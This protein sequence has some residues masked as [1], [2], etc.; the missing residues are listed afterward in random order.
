MVGNRDYPANPDLVTYPVK[1]LIVAHRMFEATLEDFIEWKTQKGFEVIVGYTD[2]IGSSTIQI[3]TWVHD[4][5]DAGTP[6]DPAPSFVLFVG[7]TGQVASETGSSSNKVTD[8]Y[9][10]SVDG[11]MFPEMYYGRFS[12]TTT[13]QLQTQIDRTL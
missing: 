2:I 10:C 8:L 3:K 11:D 4:Q 9:Y 13:D 1:Y 7:D 12:A 6:L 5:Y